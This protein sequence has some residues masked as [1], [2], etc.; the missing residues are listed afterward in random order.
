MSTTSQPTV[1]PL[2]DRS[3]D[4]LATFLARARDDYAALQA[5]GLALDL[6]RGK[7][8]SAQLDLADALLHLPTTTRDRAGVDVRNYGGLDGLAEL[9][10]L[11]AELL[12]V[13]PEQVVCGGNSSLT[14]M[15]DTLVDLLLHG[16][17]DSP[18]R[19][20]RSLW[21][22]SCAPCPVTTATSRCSPAS[23]SRW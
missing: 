11:F 20:R 18:G 15:H 5:R 17:P 2:A 16:A 10:E 8:S 6:T 9:R 4:E 12:W 14:M 22:S 21:S 19:G 13:E 23:A 1:S 7:P 3:P